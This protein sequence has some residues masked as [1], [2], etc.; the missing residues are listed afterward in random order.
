METRFQII[1]RKV[2]EINHKKSEMAIKTIHSGLKNIW[3]NESATLIFDSI[4]DEPKTITA[5]SA[6]L[7][8]QYEVNGIQDDVKDCLKSFYE[9]GILKVDGNNPFMEMIST[10]ANRGLIR[11]AKPDDSQILSKMLMESTY[12]NPYLNKMEFTADR[13]E[14]SIVLDETEYYI[15]VDT[16]GNIIAA[17]CLKTG[18]VATLV[19]MTVYSGNIVDADLNTLKET[20]NKDT[21]LIPTLEQNYEILKS[22]GIKKAGTLKNET[23]LGDVSLYYI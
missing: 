14:K 13:I 9:I 22:S 1:K 18:K 20:L 3:L 11:K 17:Y 10:N 12:V 4:Y 15:H 21:I 7:E 23:R 19:T 5:I 6:I 8:K 2:V 16:S